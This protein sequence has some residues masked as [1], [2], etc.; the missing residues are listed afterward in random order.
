MG[1]K[2]PL[3][4]STSRDGHGL[5]HSLIK[6]GPSVLHQPLHRNKQEKSLLPIK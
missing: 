3:E 1:K 5:A 6:I 4:S 2:T